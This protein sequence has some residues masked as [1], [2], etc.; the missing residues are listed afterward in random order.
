VGEDLI[1][2][3]VDVSTALSGMLKSGWNAEKAANWCESHILSETRENHGVT[4]RFVG[5]ERRIRA[6]EMGKFECENFGN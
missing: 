6:C 3:I 1:Q 5:C 4:T 2:G